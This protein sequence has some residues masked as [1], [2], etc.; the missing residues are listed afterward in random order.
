GGRL[1]HFSEGVMQ[2]AADGNGVAYESVTSIEADPDGNRAI[3]TSTVLA[4]RAAGGSWGSKDVS[5]PHADVSQ[6][7]FGG[8]YKVFSSNLESA[9]IEQQ[10]STLLSPEASEE[11]PYLRDNADGTYRPLVTSK[12][13]YANVPPGTVF[14][15][16]QVIGRKSPVRVAASNSTLTHVVLKSRTPL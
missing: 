5:P 16:G 4:R 6:L 10:D 9:L 8:E 2:A 7:R 1:V 13:G 3:D 11:T 15:G 14:G 12:E